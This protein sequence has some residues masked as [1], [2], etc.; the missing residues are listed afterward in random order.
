MQALRENG[1]IVGL[2]YG[3]WRYDPFTWLLLDLLPVSQTSYK[4]SKQLTISMTNGENTDNFTALH[5]SNLGFT[6]DTN[7]MHCS[8]HSYRTGWVKRERD[9][10][11]FGFMIENTNVTML[12]S[13]LL[14]VVQETL[15]DLK[16]KKWGEIYKY[17]SQA[18]THKIQ[19]PNFLCLTS[20][21]K[22]LSHKAFTW[23]LLVFQTLSQ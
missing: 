22:H 4:V 13:F 10:S 11:S 6:F 16:K 21:D 2:H 18:K 3:R 15:N 7:L 23:L 5:T 19:A 17:V 9:N 20:S 1:F 8:T 14:F 12:W